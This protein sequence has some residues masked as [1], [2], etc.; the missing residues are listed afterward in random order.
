MPDESTGLAGPDAIVVWSGAVT[1]ITTGLGLLWRT[2]R[3]LRRV[4]HR[5]ELF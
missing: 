5:A 3:G 1:S 4:L 2:P